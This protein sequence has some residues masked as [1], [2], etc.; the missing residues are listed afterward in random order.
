LLAG[1]RSRIAYEDSRTTT[2]TLAEPGRE[3]KPEREPPPPQRVIGMGKHESDWEIRNLLT[4]DLPLSLVRGNQLASAFVS[5]AGG[6]ESTRQRLPARSAVWMPP[7]PPVSWRGVTAHGRWPTAC[8]PGSARRRTRQR[9][10]RRQRGSRLRRLAAR[11]HARRD[12]ARACYRVAARPNSIAR[13]RCQP[14]DSSSQAP[15]ARRA[16]PPQRAVRRA[17]S[18]S[19]GRLPHPASWT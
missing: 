17:T 13:R 12:S 10:R 16:P 19:P 5:G 8:S 14:C 2:G 4:D 7:R 9:G 6:D 15:S 1:S 18:S 3:R 11:R